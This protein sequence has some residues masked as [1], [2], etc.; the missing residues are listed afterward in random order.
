MKSLTSL[1]YS[2]SRLVLIIF[3]LTLC[4][5]LLIGRIEAKDFMI[6]AMSVLSY[7]FTKQTPGAS[8]STT[9]DSDNRP[10]DVN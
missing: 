6:A 1:L 9:P 5:G 10:H 2:A 3:S 4:I 7:Y 8:S